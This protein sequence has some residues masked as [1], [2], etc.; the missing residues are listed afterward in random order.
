VGG[1]EG[2]SELSPHSYLHIMC[3]LFRTPARAARSPER[4][5]TKVSRSLRTLSTAGAGPH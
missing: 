1:R 3:V 5:L 2:A 4:W